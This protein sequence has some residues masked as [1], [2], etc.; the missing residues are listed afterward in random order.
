[1]LGV[2]A[3]SAACNGPQRQ[4]TTAKAPPL[5]G[6]SSDAFAAAKAAV[7]GSL[8]DPDS[9]K[10]RDLRMVHLTGDK[11][12]SIDAVCGFYNAKN[13]MGGFNGFSPF[14][15]VAKVV[16]KSPDEMGLSHYREKQLVMVDTGDSEIQG[17]WHQDDVDHLCGDTKA[18]PDDE[19]LTSQLGIVTHQQ[20]QKSLA[21]Q[22]QLHEWAVKRDVEISKE[23]DD[24]EKAKKAAD[25][26]LAKEIAE[27]KAS[28]DAPVQNVQ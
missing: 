18:F 6:I 22:Q 25:D 19:L 27:R 24:E 13:S 3:L 28:L 26:P 10:L 23:I 15:Y 2:C 16:E 7:I 4:A 1:M 21:M 12:S 8:K 20:M 5:T 14:T 9:A 11:G 17:R